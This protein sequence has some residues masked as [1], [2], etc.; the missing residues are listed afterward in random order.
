MINK[1]NY[2]IS[3][4]SSILICIVSVC[5]HIATILL[6]GEVLLLQLLVWKIPCWHLWI[7]LKQNTFWWFAESL[8]KHF[9]SVPQIPDMSDFIESEAEESDQEFEEKD[10]RP[11]KKI[12]RFMVEDGEITLIFFFWT[13]LECF[14]SIFF[15]LLHTHSV[16][17]LTI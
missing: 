8:L 16:K 17:C 10:P 7:A 14:H 2:I 4:F 12:Q 11:N 1:R 6:V 3:I 5:V 9:S 15:C 13:D